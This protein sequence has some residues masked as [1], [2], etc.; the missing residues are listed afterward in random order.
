MQ[1][2]LLALSTEPPILGCAGFVSKSYSNGSE[3]DLAHEYTRPVCPVNH[4]FGVIGSRKL[5]HV[6]SDCVA[7]R[8]PLHPN[9]CK[10]LEFGR[11]FS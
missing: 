11:S 1:L 4:D 9:S 2:F 6:F 7:H 3:G 5:L 8:S 10:Y